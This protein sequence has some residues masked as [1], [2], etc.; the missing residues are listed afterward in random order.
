MADTHVAYPHPEVLRITEARYSR[1]TLLIMGLASISIGT[2][3]FFE[4]EG[5]RLACRREFPTQSPQCELTR[6]SL[7]RSETSAIGS[8]L[9][10]TVEESCDEDG[11]TY[12]TLVETSTGSH[13]LSGYSSSFGDRASREIHAYLNQPDQVEL[14]VAEHTGRWLFGS[15]GGLMAFCGAGL[16][17]FLFFRSA[18]VFDKRNYNLKI[19][20][21]GLFKYQIIDTPLNLINSIEVAEQQG[22][23][24]DGDEYLHHGIRLVTSVQDPIWITFSDDQYPFRLG[25]PDE[26][27]SLAD[28]IGSFL[29]VPVSD[30]HA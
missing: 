20:Q 16:I 25:S 27:K 8:L 22:V 23:D 4:T 3:I 6:A 2:Y 13:G 7:T 24:S 18:F 12:R 9:G 15:L 30:P 17:V 14:T 5:S 1:L 26:A 29:G 19:H 21:V 11:C 10:A 28:Q